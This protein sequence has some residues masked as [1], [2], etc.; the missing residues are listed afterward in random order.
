MKKFLLL[1][2]LCSLLLGVLAWYGWERY[3][4]F[5][6]APLNIPADGQVFELGSGATGS[7]IVQ[8]LAGMGLTRPGWEWRLLMRLEPHIYQTGEY[9]L[10]A[11]SGPQAVLG[12]LASGQVIQYRFTLVEGWT[13][14]QLSEAL[15]ENTTLLQ[16]REPGVELQWADPGAGS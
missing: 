7:G 10:E 12:K 9:L 11:G 14:R 16:E 5:L 13:F 4:N 6:A 3:R 1:L 8:Q 15:A 2:A